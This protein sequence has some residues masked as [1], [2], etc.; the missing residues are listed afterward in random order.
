MRSWWVPSTIA[1]SLIASAGSADSAEGSPLAV[2]RMLSA[3]R[4][5]A[6]A[7]D[8]VASPVAIERRCGRDVLCAARMI[9]NSAGPGAALVRVHTPDTDTIRWVKTRPSVTRIV[10]EEDGRRVIAL[11][12]FGRTVE[13]EMIAAL[14]ATGAAGQ[15]EIVIDL[16]CNGGGDFRRML[17]VAGLFTGPVEHALS[18]VDR[19]GRRTIVDIPEVG[20]RA[21]AGPLAVIVGPG[22]ASSAEVLTLLLGKYAAASILGARTYGKDYL[23]RV[24]PVTHDW[25]MVLPSAKIEVPGHAFADG[26]EPDHVETEQSMTCEKHR[27]PS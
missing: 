23:T 12:H 10:D 25:N 19:H 17:G 26:I 21:D 13:R 27:P 5:Y 24:I 18:L 3:A 4:E 9:V 16:R 14:S 20:W 8:A 6:L 22:T 11:D 15:S 7:A 2:E 1:I